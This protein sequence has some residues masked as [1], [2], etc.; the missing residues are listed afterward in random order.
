MLEKKWCRHLYLMVV[1]E[2]SMIDLEMMDT[3]PWKPS[4]A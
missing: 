2:A 1:E 3:R 4:F